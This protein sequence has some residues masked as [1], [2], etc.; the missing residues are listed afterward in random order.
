[1]MHQQPGIRIIPALRDSTKLDPAFLAIILENLVSEP[2]ETGGL[3]EQ[4]G[5]LPVL[6]GGGGW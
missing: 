5:G 1:M 3:G 2:A 4:V 6:A